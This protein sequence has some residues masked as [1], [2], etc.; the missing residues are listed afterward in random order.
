MQSIGS[1]FA[2]NQIVIAL[3]NIGGLIGLLFLIVN[4]ANKAF[5]FLKSAWKTSIVKAWREDRRGRQRLIVIC[6]RDLHTYFSTVAGIFS[7]CGMLGLAAVFLLMSPESNSIAYDKDWINPTT[8]NKLIVFSY[9][10]TLILT[11]LYLFTFLTT[12]RRR[13][14]RLM[15]ARRLWASHWPQPLA[16]PSTKG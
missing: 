14:R 8:I 4:A 15:K 1:L 10:L 2:E 16:I 5:Q 9:T 6:A 3:V 12:V 7:L 13:R 11:L